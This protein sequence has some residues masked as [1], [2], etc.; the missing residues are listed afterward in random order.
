MWCGECLHIYMLFSCE[1]GFVAIYAVLSQNQF[2]CNLRIFMWTKIQPKI[3]YVE[4]I[5]QIWGTPLCVND[6]HNIHMCQQFFVDFSVNILSA[7]LNNL[8][9]TLLTFVWIE[10]VK[11]SGGI[12]ESQHI[13]LIIDCC[14]HKKSKLLPNDLIW[15]ICQSSEIPAAV[16]PPIVRSS[17]FLWF[18][19]SPKPVGSQAE[20]RCL[21]SIQVAR[22][23]ASRQASRLARHQSNRT[24]RHHHK[25]TP[26]RLC[27]EEEEKTASKQ[28]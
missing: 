1:I 11:G 24:H 8:S 23:Q 20:T 5:L 16:L 13:V 18:G 28:C 6:I 2:C 25:W 21:S 15:A 12:F 22:A 4:K 9:T 17:F 27:E 10:I 7:I 19:T 26:Y 3:A 14:C